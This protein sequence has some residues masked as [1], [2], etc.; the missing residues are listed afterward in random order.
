MVVAKHRVI[1]FQLHVYILLF[2]AYTKNDSLNNKDFLSLPFTIPIPEIY[3]LH[4][5]V[6]SN[7]TI[8]K[9][10]AVHIR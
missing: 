6:F 1:N 2:S 9:S 10:Y 7:R 5:Y 4:F 3:H 8:A